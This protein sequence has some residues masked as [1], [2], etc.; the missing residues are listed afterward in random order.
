MRTLVFIEHQGET[1][2]PASLAV[3]ARAAA[4]G[5][6]DALLAGS[7]MSGLAELAGRHGAR[8]VL[9]ADDPALDS[10]LP[11]PRVDVLA[12]LAADYDNVFFAQSVLAADVAAGLAAR[13]E[14]GV[15]WGLVAVEDRDGTLVGRQLVL[16][17]T[18]AVESAWASA[19]RIALFRDGTGEPHETGGAGEV[20]PVAVALEPFSTAARIVESTREESGGRALEDAEVVVAGGRGVGEAAGFAALERLADALGGAVAATGAAVGAGWYPRAAQVGQTGKTVA[21]RLYL[22]CGISGAIQ[23]RVGMQRSGTIVAINTDPRA[24]IM[25]LADLCVVGDLKTIVPRL[26]ELLRAD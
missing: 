6:A 25:E 7:G 21:P 16:G 11:Q 18:L 1:I 22:A 12:P 2:R 19:P 14:A 24:P 26:T 4:L 20:V 17:D 15:N 10:P 8:C 23:H 9:V 3:L 5:E 13:L